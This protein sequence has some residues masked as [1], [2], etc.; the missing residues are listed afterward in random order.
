MTCC[1]HCCF[2]V[3]TY[4][5]YLNPVTGWAQKSLLLQMVSTYGALNEV[6]NEIPTGRSSRGKVYKHCSWNWRCWSKHVKWIKMEILQ[7]LLGW[8][9]CH[10]LCGVS[11]SRE[12]RTSLVLSCTESPCSTQARD[13]T[14]KHSFIREGNDPALHLRSLFFTFLLYDFRSKDDIIWSLCRVNSSY[15]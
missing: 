12:I 3:G 9:F 4:F 6:Q 11:L 5:R 10:T 13:A 14:C 8:H 1:L 2:I 7:G 15:L